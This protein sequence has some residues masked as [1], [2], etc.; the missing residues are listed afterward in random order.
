MRVAFINYRMARLLAFDFC[1]LRVACLHNRISITESGVMAEYSKKVQSWVHGA[2]LKMFD[3]YCVKNE[4]GESEGVRECLK[5]YYA[6][7]KGDFILRIN[8]ILNIDETKDITFKRQL[9]SMLS[10]NDLKNFVR[11]KAN[12]YISEADLIRESI[13]IKVLYDKANRTPGFTENS[14]ERQSPNQL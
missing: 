11:V 7:L 3:E 4:Y 8:P 10:G 2:L 5:Y 9:Q 13:R 1:L 12:L 6:Y 14:R